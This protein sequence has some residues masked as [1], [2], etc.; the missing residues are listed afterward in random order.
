MLISIRVLLPGNPDILDPTKLLDPAVQ[1]QGILDEIAVFHIGALCIEP[2]IAAP[3]V[4]PTGH[5]ANSVLGVRQDGD[6]KS[7]ALLEHCVAFE[8]PL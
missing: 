3:M 1:L 2:T 5:A 7:R 8:S 4:G 6:N